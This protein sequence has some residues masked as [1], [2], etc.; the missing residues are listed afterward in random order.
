ML[1]FTKMTPTCF[2]SVDPSLGSNVQC[3]A[4]ITIMVHSVAQ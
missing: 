3:L 4:E 1:K 2:G